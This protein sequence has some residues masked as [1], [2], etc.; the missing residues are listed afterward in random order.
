[1]F[2]QLMSIFPIRA[3]AIIVPNDG[4]LPAFSVSMEAG[5]DCEIELCRIALP[6]AALPLGPRTDSDM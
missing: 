4:H 2:E 5:R 6:G 3:T 1:M